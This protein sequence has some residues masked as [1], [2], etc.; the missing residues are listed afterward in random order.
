MWDWGLGWGGEQCSCGWACKVELKENGTR[1]LVLALVF[2]GISSLSLG[3]F[4]LEVS[5]AC[6]MEIVLSNQTISQVVWRLKI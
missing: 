1:D 5:S 6:E 4:P 2:P 3:K